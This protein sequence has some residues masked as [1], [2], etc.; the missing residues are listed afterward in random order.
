M[1][2]DEKD[3]VGSIEFLEVVGLEG[4]TYKLKGPNGEEVKLN[5]SEIN[6]EDELQIGEEYSFFV[7]PNRSG[8]LFATQNMPDITTN[9][10][11]FVKVLKTDRDGAH[12]DVGLPREVLIPWEDLPKVKDV[13]PVQGDE[14]FVT[15]RIDRDNN[16]FARLATET[17]V[18]QMY[19]PVF[20]DEKQNQVIEARPYRLLRIGSFLLSKYGYKIFVHETE[21]KEEPRLGENVSVRI[22]G[23]NEK[24]ELNGSFLPLAHERL[25]DDGQHIFDLLVEYDGELPFS[26]KSSP[27]AIKEIFNMSKGSFKRA[28]GHLYKNKIITIESGK[29]ALTQKGWGRIEK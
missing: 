6:D 20:D 26:D 2:Q 29:I 23:H 7:Y 1:A 9:K 15:L 27:E 22:I 24:G 14:L 17:I 21:R 8:A 18:E 11:D 13:W 4:S 3:I 10:Y 28:I 12:V 25:D 19:T 5:Q 16:M